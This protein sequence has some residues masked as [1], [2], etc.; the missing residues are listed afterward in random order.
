MAICRVVWTDGWSDTAPNRKISKIRRKFLVPTI[1]LTLIFSPSFT[2]ILHFIQAIQAI[3][4]IQA[5]RIV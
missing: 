3:Q 4:S 5:G 1:S 2:Q